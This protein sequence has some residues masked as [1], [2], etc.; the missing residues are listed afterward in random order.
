[1]SVPAA[2]SR[3]TL[4]IVAVALVVLSLAACGRLGSEEGAAGDGTSVS[5][6]PGSTGSVAPGSAGGGEPGSTGGGDPSDAVDCPEPSPSADPDTPV[7]TV[8]PPDDGTGVP[9]PVPSPVEPRPGMANVH[10]VGWETYE[11]AEDGESVTV[12]YWSGVEP[13]SVLDH[14]E[15]N[16]GEDTITITL[17]EGNDP[18]AGD[19]ACIEIAMYKSVTVA[20]DQ[21]VAGR[22]IVD[23][24]GDPASE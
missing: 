9:D 7:C 18:D 14:V 22:T 6:E 11:L 12:A 1:M 3:T 8:V 24:A 13:C 15:V 20:L 5:G 23:G 10:V 2:S 19:V 17:Y 16:Y 4:R 21:D